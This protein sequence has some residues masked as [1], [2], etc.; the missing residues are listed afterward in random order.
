M[1]K[2][3]VLLFALSAMPAFSQTV[4]NAGTVKISQAISRDELGVKSCGLNFVIGVVESDK[5][6]TLYD[7]SVNIWN[8]AQGM[9]KAGSHTYLN[10]KSKTRVP[11]P[12]LFWIAKRDDSAAIRPESYIKAETPGFILGGADALAVTQV[13]M[14]VIEG[15]PM[16]FS[17]QYPGERIS[18]VVGFRSSMTSDERDAMHECMGALIK[19]MRTEGAPE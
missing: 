12:Q 16:Q 6:A 7:F 10:A 11:G 5:K 18:P 19:R 2:I 9:V 14:G 15:A 4:V 8:F 1:K 13:L 3:A 17:L